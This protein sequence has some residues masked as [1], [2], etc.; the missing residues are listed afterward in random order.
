MAVDAAGDAEEALGRALA[1]ENGWSRSSTSLGEQLRAV[2]VGAG[3]EQVGTPITSAARRAATS[4]R[5]NWLSARAPCRPCGRTSSRSRSWSSKW[6][7]AAPASIMRLHQLEGVERAAE[8]GLGVGDDRREPVVLA[9][10]LGVL[11][12]V[13]ALQR[14]VDALDDGGHAVGRGRATGRGTSAPAGWRRR[15]PASP[16]GRWP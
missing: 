12:L 14:L 7:P 3:D 5:M 6:T 9:L 11:D 15:R 10:A 2:G 4:V 16:R 13:G 8:A 1:G